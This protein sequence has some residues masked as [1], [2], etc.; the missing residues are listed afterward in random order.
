MRRPPP[1]L[2]EQE[3][4]PDF[5]SFT[6]AWFDRGDEVAAYEAARAAERRRIVWAFVGV[7]GALTAAFAVVLLLI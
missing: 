3:E 4:S 7:F 5:G 6:R 1:R 2:R